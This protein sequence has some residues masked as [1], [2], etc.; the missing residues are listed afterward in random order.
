MKQMKP[1]LI[2]SSL[3]IAI[4]SAPSTLWINQG[5]NQ[6]VFGQEKR[7]E[8]ATP[9][10]YLFVWT[11]DDDQKDSDFLAVI[12]AL[13]SSP[14][15]GEIIATLPVGVRATSPHHTEYEFPAGAN[16]FANG[17]G[18]GRTFIIDLNNPKKPSL[19][20]QFTHTTDYGFPH[21][22][23][24]LPNGNVLATFQVKR[25]SYEPPGGLV[26][27]TLGLE[28]LD[29]KVEFVS[30]FPGAGTKFECGVPVVVGKFWIQT[31]PSLPGLIALD[32]S[33]PAKP[34]EV[35]RL[36]FD[37]RFE[38]THWIAADRSAS[39]VVVTGND[40]SWVLIVNIDKTT[41][42]MTLDEN[43]KAR[44]A[45]HPGIDFDRPRWPHGTTGKGVV[46]GALFGPTWKSDAHLML[47]IIDA[48]AG[49]SSPTDTI[50]P[51]RAAAERALA[52]DPNLAEA[53]ASRGHVRWKDRDWAGAEADFN[54]A[55]QRQ[56]SILLPYGMYAEAIVSLRKAVDLGGRGQ[57]AVGSLAHA[58]AVSGNKSE[59][60]ELL[61]VL[62]RTARDQYV[63]RYILATVYTG[64][65]DKARA[66]DLLEAAYKERGIDLLQIKVDPKL[67]PLRDEPRFQEVIRKINF[68]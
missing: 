53:H 27:L 38:K 66:L 40:R 67:N 32:I 1:I 33:N 14:T 59:A 62:E 34:V 28:G 25:K 55:H 11:G 23:A 20:G 39:R 18:A 30:S 57:L 47:G 12:D 46:H 54:I 24:R 44:G 4:L 64:L 7:P 63:S 22:F 6:A 9:S 26:E 48:M 37:N 17:W 3:I 13:P 16:L 8:S 2:T 61:A 68:P 36:V 49:A 52:I 31:D 58:C 21:S 15:Y 42:T 60:L 10:S 45:D 5:I 19:A 50:P 29:P 51:A 56:G 65:G 35:S 41:G 43:F